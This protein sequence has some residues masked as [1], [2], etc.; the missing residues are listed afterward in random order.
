MNVASRKSGLNFPHLHEPFQTTEKT[1]NGFEKT[2]VLYSFLILMTFF[3]DQT[4][5]KSK[6][7]LAACERIFIH[8]FRRLKYTEIEF[9]LRFI[10]MREG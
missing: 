2:G 1:L 4:L 9:S 3:V 8:T 5:E 7:C 6:S 10:A